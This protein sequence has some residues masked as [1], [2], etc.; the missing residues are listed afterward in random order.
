MVE[1][2]VRENATMAFNISTWWHRR[3]VQS[4][5]QFSGRA[6]Q[7]HRVT[8]PFHAVSIKAGPTCEKTALQ[9]GRTRYLSRE[10]P[11]LPLPT[12][13]PKGCTCRYLHHDDRRGGQDRRERDVWS[14]Q[15]QPA[16]S[17][18]RRRSGGRRVTDH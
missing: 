1:T 14:A 2:H 12:C 11:T 7:V 8:N 13:N 4:E 3:R 17:V 15:P 5:V 6:V 9:Y 16:A 18:E 10:A